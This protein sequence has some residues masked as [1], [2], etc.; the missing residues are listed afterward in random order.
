MSRLSWYRPSPALGVAC[1][2]LFLVLVSTGGAAVSAAP[3]NNSVGTAQLKNNAVTSAKIKNNA[4]TAAKIASN[5][6]TSAKIASNAVAGAKIASNA[7]TGA[8]VQDGSIA[9]ADLASG[10]LPPSNAVG[11]FAD[12]PINVPTA[13]AT[14]KSLSIPAAGNYVILAKT[15]LTSAVLP[16]T[17]TCRLVAGGNFDTSQAYVASG[18]PSTLSLIVLGNFTAAGTVN[19]ACS[20][21][22]PQQANFVKIVALQVAN[23]TNTG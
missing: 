8:K 9:A 19:L 23:L 21:T 16:G 6:V 20:A 11:T 4:V 10:V 3:P 2:A 17:V 15:Y 22:P 5:A 18:Q 14:I 12:G 7:V 13:E 1:L